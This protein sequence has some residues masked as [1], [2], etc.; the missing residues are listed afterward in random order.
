MEPCRISQAAV[1]LLV[2][3]GESEQ[4][5]YLL[6]AVLFLIPI[7]NELAQFEVRLLATTVG[8]LLLIN[9]PGLMWAAARRRNKIRTTGGAQL[10][11]E[12]E[13]PPEVFSLRLDRG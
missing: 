8:N 2:S 4:P 1:H 5:H 3:A 13:L 7:A 6:V 10:M 9:I 11:F 12:E